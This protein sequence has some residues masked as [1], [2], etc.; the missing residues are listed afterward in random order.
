MGRGTSSV[1]ANN[2]AR[3][4]ETGLSSPLLSEAPPPSY[5]GGGSNPAKEG[6]LTRSE[7]F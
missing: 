7:G 4:V 5:A 2:A 1:A 3:R 6:N